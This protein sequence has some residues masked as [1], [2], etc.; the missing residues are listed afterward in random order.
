MF[1][2][3]NKLQKKIT[4]HPVQCFAMIRLLNEILYSKGT[5]AEIQTEEGK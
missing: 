2:N 5:L 1:S 3:K 4:P